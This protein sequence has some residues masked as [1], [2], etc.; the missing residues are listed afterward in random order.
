[1]PNFSF[2]RSDRDSRQFQ[3]RGFESIDPSS[4]NNGRIERQNALTEAVNYDMT[5]SF[6]RQFGSVT[7]RSQ[8]R[9]QHEDQ[10]NFEERVVGNDL[11]SKGIKDLSN[12]GTSGTKEIG[13]FRSIVRSDGYYGSFGIDY[14]D[15]YIADFLIRRDGSSLFGPDERWHNYFRIS[16]AYRVSEEAWWPFADAIPEFKL[17][18]SYG[19]AG[20]RPRFEAQYET[21]SLADGVLSKNTLGNNGLKPELQTE[22]ELG[23]DIGITDRVFIELVYADSQVEDQLLQVPLAG[24]FGFASQWQNAG[25]LESNTIEASINANLIRTRDM[26]LD[27]GVI[28][29]RTDQEITEFNT[30]AFRGGPQSRF[31]FRDGELLGA[32]YGGLWMTDAS[33]LPADWA[34]AAGQFAVNDDGY[35]VPVG[36]GNA[37][38][39]GISK[40]LWGTTVDVNGTELAWGMPVKVQDEEGE[41]AFTQIADVLPDFNLGVP[42]NFRYKGFTA[43]VLLNAQVGGDVYNFT[44]QWS[45]RDGRASDQDQSGKEEGLRKTTAYYEALYEAT[46]ANSHFVEDG[47]YLK[48][49]EVALGYTFNQAQLSRVFGNTLHRLTIS[50]IGRNLLTFTD[51]TGFDPE[52]G[53]TFSS[54]GGVGS[55]A[56][57]YRVDNFSYPNYRTFT[58]KLEIQF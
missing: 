5:A 24:Y 1:M 55:D 11:V 21:F 28:F 29:D 22:L 39:E 45:Y 20:G 23:V 12:V 57:L 30:N 58:G 32:M 54:T 34:S 53:T 10:D 18:G 41:E 2:D 27:V 16:G 43:G 8:L 13:N 56:S 47:T 33:E 46:G 35:L 37:F 4:V 19:T 48:L 36:A 7:L 9:Y 50:L 40:Q 6:R 51:Y 42:I 17:R 26:S 44:K 31:Y 38:T 49:R 14:Q 25:T 3:D 15:K 52:V